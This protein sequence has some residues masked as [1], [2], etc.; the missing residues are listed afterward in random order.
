MKTVPQNSY[1]W[2]GVSLFM[3]FFIISLLVLLYLSMRKEIRQIHM[4]QSDR[5]YPPRRNTL[6]EE[7]HDFEDNKNR[8]S[9]ENENTNQSENAENL[10]EF[11]FRMNDNLNSLN[12]P[13]PLNMF[14]LSPRD[15][16]MRDRAVLQD[17]LYP[18]LNRSSLSPHDS[19][20][21]VGYLVSE[22][23]HDDS[24]QLFGRKINNT[25]S[26][27]Y[28]RP[29]NANVDMKIPI[30]DSDFIKP[31]SR[32]RDI[33]N[34]PEVTHIDNPILGSTSYKVVTNPNADFSSL[35]F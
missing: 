25:R 16:Y 10:N 24:W 20:R 13:R 17:P 4:L 15:V 3:L 1:F 35:Y 29:T 2:L 7:N 23:S 9:G 34:L 18:P 33:D 27:F 14:S 28:I 30:Q 6:K 12:L 22:E 32:L 5:V 19:Y 26:E 31:S 8:E 21:L 11:G